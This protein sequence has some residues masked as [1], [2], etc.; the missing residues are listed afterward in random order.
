[1]NICVLHGSL[2]GPLLFL[3]YIND[4]TIVGDENICILIADDTTLQFT[5]MDQCELENKLTNNLAT[6]IHGYAL[7][8]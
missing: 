6:Y 4:I 3:L 1:M 7:I 8:N 5:D 2:L